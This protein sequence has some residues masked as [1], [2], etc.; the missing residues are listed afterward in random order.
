[1]HVDHDGRFAKLDDVVKHYSKKMS[2]SLTPDQ[3]H[4]LVEF[5]KSL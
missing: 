1:M 4:D 3:Q 2:L 5:L